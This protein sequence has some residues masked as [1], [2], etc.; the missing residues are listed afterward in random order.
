MQAEGVFS[1][2]ALRD[3][4]SWGKFKPGDSGVFGSSAALVG[5]QELGQV[6]VGLSS[7]S[8]PWGTLVGRPELGQD[9]LGCSA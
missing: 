7:G 6:Q 4:G 1:G 3:D 5:W 8:L 9:G 2:S